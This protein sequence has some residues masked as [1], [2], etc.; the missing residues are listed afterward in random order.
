MRRR[1]PELERPYRTWGYP[2][3][4]IVYVVVYLWF[5]ST[6]LLQRP[7]ESGVGL[8]IIALGAPAYYLWTR[9]SR[10]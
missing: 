7:L 5:L 2:V 1:R 4:P 10:P 6:I 8:V 9:G 3:V